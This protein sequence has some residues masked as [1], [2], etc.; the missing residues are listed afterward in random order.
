VIGRLWLTQS[1]CHQT[2]SQIWGEKPH[3]LPSRYPGAWI[4]MR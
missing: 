1:Q 4:L 3:L 2:E